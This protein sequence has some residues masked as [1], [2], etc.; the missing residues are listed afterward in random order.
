MQNE[1]PQELPSTYA[2]AGV[3]IKAGNEVV[4]RIKPHAKRTLTPGV[5]SAIGGFG[6]LFQPDLKN[7]TEPVLVSATDGVGTKLK[8]AFALNKHDT[9]GVDLVAMCVNDVLCC[10]AK[11]L[12]FLDYFATGQLSPDVA[13]SVVK[14]IADGCVQSHCAL[15]GGETAELPGMYADGEYDLGGF[16]VGIVDKSKILD[17]ATIQAGDVILGV[18]SSGLHSNGYSLARKLLEPLGYDSFDENL[19]ATIGAAMLS[20]TKIYVRAMSDAL[21]QGKVKGLVHITGGGFYENIPRVLPPGTA[22]RIERDS[23][24]IPPIFALLQNQ[25]NIAE[26]E[27]FTTFNMGIGLV[28]VV[29]REDENAARE[30]INQSGE[31]VQRIGEIVATNEAPHVELA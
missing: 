27:M 3:D 14:G 29:A 11:P 13:E 12:F 21:A 20:P 4:R 10:G 25:G 9:I 30:M 7:F 15:I 1:L 31:S 22:A 2:A 24:P 23:W 28:I 6:A 18:A 26:R 5:L 19:G 8:L 17:G 16:C